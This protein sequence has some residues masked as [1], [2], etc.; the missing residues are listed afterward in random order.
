[1]KSLPVHMSSPTRNV[2]FVAKH[3][4]MKLGLLH[5]I[6]KTNP[7]AESRAPDAKVGRT[8]VALARGVWPLQRE[9]RFQGEEFVKKGSR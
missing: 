2:T 4:R 1:M 8:L 9:A 7:C 3:L 6:A 5:C